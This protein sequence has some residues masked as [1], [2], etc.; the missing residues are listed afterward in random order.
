VKLFGNDLLE[1]RQYDTSLTAYQVRYSVDIQ[2][3]CITH[4]SSTVPV[5]R[6]S[7]SPAISGRTNTHTQ[8]RPQSLASTG[9]AGQVWGCTAGPAV[10][11]ADAC[12]ST[13]PLPPPPLQRS[14]VRLDIAAAALN[15]GQALILA[16][17]MTGAMLAAALG[18]ATPSA[19][20]VAA[21]VTA[22]G[23]KVVATT[24]AGITAGD[25]VMIQG[26]LLHLWAP[27]QF[28]VSCQLLG[29]LQGTNV[30]HT[31]ALP[32]SQ[33][34]PT[35]A[36]RA[37]CLLL[38]PPSAVRLLTSSLQIPPYTPACLLPCSHHPFQH[39]YHLN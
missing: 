14:V 31:H 34:R 17:G 8:G 12:P 19:A 27:L 2:L 1:V 3:V 36:R 24:A 32:R 16:G 4:S 39:P 22:G 15:A 28:L 9:T 25:L 30:W 20:A 35:Q 21:A 6:C 29:W 37:A 38:T 7:C 33:P 26:L 10:A 5:T 23:S 11:A 13:T 18:T